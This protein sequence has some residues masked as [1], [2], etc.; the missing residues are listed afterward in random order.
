[1]AK[2]LLLICMITAILTSLFTPVVSAA[3]YREFYVSPTG[4]DSNPGTES[5]PFQTITKAKAEVAKITGGMTGDIVV[6]IKEGDY[7]LDNTVTFGSGDSGKNSGAVVRYISQPGNT[8]LPRIIGGQKVT[9][10]TLDDAAKG[11]YKANVGAGWIFNSLYVNG[12]P[13]DMARWPKKS[14]EL[15]RWTFLYSGRGEISGAHWHR[16]YFNR[17]DFAAFGDLSKLNWVGAQAFFLGTGRGGGRPDEY[18][19]V[20]A[21]T[22][23][24]LNNNIITLREDALDPSNRWLSV[25]N[26]APY[27]LYGIREFL[28]DENE[29]HLDRENGVLYYKPQS[30]ANI[31]NLEIIAPKTVGIFNLNNASYISFEGLQIEAADREEFIPAWRGWRNAL[32]VMSNSRNIT[33]DGCNLYNSGDS[34]VSFNNGSNSNVNIINSHMRN[35]GYSALNL[36][37][38]GNNNTIDSNLIENTGLINSY[39]WSL[40]V[41]GGNDLYFTH[42]K[43]KGAAGAGIYTWGVLNNCHF[44]YNEFTDCMQFGSD[45]GV[46]YFVDFYGTNARYNYVEGNYTHNNGNKLGPIV[47][48]HG[49]VLHSLY[50]D[51]G[52]NKFIARNNILA[53]MESGYDLYPIY[54]KGRNIVIENNIVYQSARSAGPNRLTGVISYD[55]GRPSNVVDIT[56]RHNIFYLP[57]AESLYCIWSWNRYPKGDPN[58][59]KIIPWDPKMFT[60]A[61]YNLLYFPGASAYRVIA[62]DLTDPTK[63][64]EGF[65]P[66]S[67]WRQTYGLDTHSIT[68]QDPLFENPAAGNFALK[69]NSPAWQLGFQPIDQSIVGPFPHSPTSKISGVT[70][71]NIQKT[72]VGGS[73]SVKGD[74]VNT[75]GK[76]VR[77]YLANYKDNKLIAL[78]SD[79]TTGSGSFS[80]TLPR[81]QSG[82]RIKLMLWT[83]SMEPVTDCI[84][85]Y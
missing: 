12:E 25:G 80:V 84:W 8:A 60:Q 81:R 27:I 72:V 4:N 48:T 54:A 30:G 2:K 74:I 85:I 78:D 43:V 7:F 65:F 37:S 63:E 39:S 34:L 69:S 10:W 79:I 6:Y 9:G 42:N 35:A 32:V 5:L 62:Q 14:A 47:G 57:G 82:E 21:I 52:A 53:E 23:I 73:I 16:F 56:L 1:M 67:W 66:I 13:A 64:Q 50:F 41:W 11:I 29:F 36:Q 55:D 40:G 22:G 15:G 28:T 24:D 58:E 38:G 51:L 83:G 76:P 20:S 77:A 75:T 61:D 68:G 18:A 49:Q 45:F 26:G 71:S 59:G 17:A 33:V 70:V 31:N 46:I 44:S 3:A 19:F